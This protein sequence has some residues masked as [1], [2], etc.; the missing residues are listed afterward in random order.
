[1]PPSKE[2]LIGFI[3]APFLYKDFFKFGW[4]DFEDSFFFQVF[5]I[6]DS[7]ERSLIYSS[8]RPLVDIPRIEKQVNLIDQKFQIFFYPKSRNKNLIETSLLILTLGLSF[9][10]LI[11]KFLNDT[12]KKAEQVSL[13]E[14]YL[15]ESLRA[16]DEFISIASH[17]LKT[18]LTS[19]KLRA[20]LSKRKLQRQRA[21]EKDVIEFSTEIE[22]Q[23]DRLERLVNDIL[24][25]SRIRTGNF[26]LQPENFDLCNLIEEII[27][28]MAP[29]FSSPDRVQL[30]THNPKIEVFW[31]KLRIDQI[32]TNLLTNA[33]KYGQN[34]PVTISVQE[35]NG[36]VLFSVKDEGMGIDPK[37]REA[38][39]NRFERA[40]ISPNEIS[41]LG[42][43]LYI[44]YKIVSAHRG[45]IWVDSELGKGSTFFIKI[46]KYPSF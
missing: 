2:S 4:E 21:T 41:G 25:I 3:F 1:K 32:I 33:Q 46:A 13:N 40:G 12:I 20:Q 29:Q 35:N 23:V 38:I 30:I 10:L 31:D 6:N 11:S 5:D 18:P 36:E 19:L 27:L 17:E 14:S 34:S 28:R 26:S 39:F 9:T 37:F 16:R 44:T 45:K 24:D 42:L 15:E 8:I 22:K 43:G 7:Q